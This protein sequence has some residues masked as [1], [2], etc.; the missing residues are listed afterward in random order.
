[1]PQPS[2]RCGMWR[3]SE[4]RRQAWWGGTRFTAHGPTGT[5]AITALA[6]CILLGLGSW[7]L[8]AAAHFIDLDGTQKRDIE[9]LG[10]FDRNHAYLQEIRPGNPSFSEIELLFASAGYQ[11][12][13]GLGITLKLYDDTGAQ[14][15]GGRYSIPKEA[16]GFE[17]DLMFEPQGHSAGRLYRVTLETDAP[18]D[19]VSL[20]GSE[21]D[22]Y[23]EGRLLRN[24]TPVPLD[25][26]F[27]A[28]ST[29]GPL[30]LIRRVVQGSGSRPVE[31]LFIS[32]IFW[33]TGVAAAIHLARP[34]D[35]VELITYPLAAGLA[36]IPLMLFL[37]S[38]GGVPLR[39]GNLIAALAALVLISIVWMVHSGRGSLGS[40]PLY[41]SW[42]ARETIPLLVLLFFA[43]F[44]RM[45][46]VTE[47][48]VP[49]GID[50]LA[51]Q[52]ILQ[53]IESKEQ[54]PLD[55]IYPMGF[56]SNVFLLHALTGTPLPEET[57]VFGQ[58]LSILSGLSVYVL[59]RKLLKQ[60]W[61][62][63]AAAAAFWFISPIPALLVNWGRYPFLQGL[64]LL[65]VALAL[66][67][68]GR[69]DMSRHGL[70]AGLLAAGLLFS[71]YGLFL[72]YA[73]LAALTF[74]SRRRPSG[75]WVI[76]SRGALIALALVA[77][78]AGLVLIGKSYGVLS[79]G[80]W[81]YFYRQAP[82]TYG[83]WDY[84]HFLSHTVKHGGPLAWLLGGTG[85]VLLCRRDRRALVLSMLTGAGLLLLDGL[86]ME[87]FH[88][89]AN[90]PVNLL[91]FLFVPLC[92]LAGFTFKA[93][94]QRARWVTYAFAT[95]A[96]IAGSYN[97]SAI[98][99]P[100]NVFYTSA[101]REAMEWIQ[102][103]TPVE[104]L[105]LVNS[106]LYDGEY[107]PE[108][109]GGWIPYLTGR[110]ITIL[111]SAEEYEQADAAISR[112]GADYIYIGS[113]YGLLG[114]PVIGDPDYELVYARD[115]T[116]IYRA[117][118]QD[119]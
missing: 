98:T 15:A 48:R 52:R 32:L 30:E 1:M 69:R 75:I 2:A 9:S 109:G 65:P 50:G 61:Y 28:Y 51:H 91:Y 77:V 82:L 31:L 76:P 108:D 97:I 36:V 34:R 54:V 80:T 92:V 24:G 78:P 63:L 106:Y 60:S 96:A 16:G 26:G 99:D 73:V 103:H 13:A 55:S 90:R 49:S 12:A 45:A 84:E 21:Y 43:V 14:I 25:L 66:L 18:P 62:A 11:N 79:Q 88:H 81:S 23:V 58:W 39:R 68:D 38:L 93:L 47:L 115:G 22:A 3:W 59:A 117:R 42:R 20:R 41:F 100:V 29:P 33:G 57:L 70:L 114:F 86:Q 5:A 102:A 101:D 116:F 83:P 105:F 72:I 111:T 46:Q 71:H 95:A 37:L 107:Q 87:I 113:G 40:R 7:Y 44:T 110:K 17:A 4:P 74:L 56:H 112:T 104:S 85:Y 64:A 67:A 19:T 6:V 35:V 89:S 94:F 27:R 53:R 118:P 8:I 10:P 119:R